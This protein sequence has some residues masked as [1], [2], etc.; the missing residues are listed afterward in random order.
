MSCPDSDSE[1]RVDE[2]EDGRVVSTS[3]GGGL[4]RRG[5]GVRAGAG[6]PA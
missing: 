5:S 6:A 4:G 1:L 2:A 3:L